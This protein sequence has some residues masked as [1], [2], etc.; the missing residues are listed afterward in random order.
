MQS[1]F[2]VMAGRWFLPQQLWKR[3]LFRGICYISFRW[4][5]Y[6]PSFRHATDHARATADISARITRLAALRQGDGL[7]RV[8]RF[9]N[10]KRKNC[11]LFEQ[12]GSRHG[13]K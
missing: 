12:Q 5:R 6:E 2:T 10:V 11:Q 4:T 1:D 3:S 9:L 8:H 7:S 13:K